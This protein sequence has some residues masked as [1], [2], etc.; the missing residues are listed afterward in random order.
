MQ[1]LSRTNYFEQMPTMRLL[2]GSENEVDRSSLPIG[3]MAHNRTMDDKEF[4]RRLSEV[5][6]WTIP[7]TEQETS[8]NAKKKRGR[9]TNEELYQ[10]EHEQ[11]F[12]EIFEGVNPTKA[13]LLLKIK[14]CPYNCEC[15]RT[16]T[17]GCQKEAKLYQKSGKAHWRW[18]CKS[19]G[20]TQDPYTGE[21]SL[22]SQKAS[23][24]WHSFLKE[25]KGLYQS[26]GNM[27]KQKQVFLIRKYPETEQPL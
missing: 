21:Y 8:N 15:G 14:Y 13:P 25:S 10:E 23:V 18:K 2:Y 24:V 6:E 17:D 16:C 11:I 4:K 9:K 22:S 19:C 3:K 1:R 26:K 27:V 7:E 5:A 12:L 20:M